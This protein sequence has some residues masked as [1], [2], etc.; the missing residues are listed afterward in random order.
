MTIEGGE[1]EVIITEDLIDVEYIPVEVNTYYTP[2]GNVVHIMGQDTV[3][4]YVYDTTVVMYNE[5][6]M[7]N[8]QGQFTHNNVMTNEMIKMMPEKNTCDLSR[9][10]IDDAKVL[11]AFI[12]GT[13]NFTDPYLYLAADLDDNMQVDFND[14]LHIIK[15]VSGET[16]SLPCIEPYWFVEETETASNPFDLAIMDPVDFA[17]I[18]L[19]GDSLNGTY[20]LTV[21]DAAGKEVYKTSQKAYSKQMNFEVDVNDFTSGYYF[22]NIQ[23]TS[24]SYK[25]TFIKN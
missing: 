20:Q 18:S 7:T 10:D 23:G 12:T 19:E 25:G 16:N 8:F 17:N 24:K 9:I 14:L 2:L 4:T 11:H 13:T 5:S 6:I 21:Y 22:Y 15:F 1:P 3:N